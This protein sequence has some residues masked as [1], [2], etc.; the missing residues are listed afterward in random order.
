MEYNTSRIT[1]GI[2][3]PCVKLILTNDEIE[4]TKNNNGAIRETDI[5]KSQ[6]DFTRSDVNKKYTGTI[7]V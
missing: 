4:S 6:F 1:W 2:K 3:T 7:I 5:L